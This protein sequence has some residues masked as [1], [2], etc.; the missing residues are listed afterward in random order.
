V[1]EMIYRR[2]GR[3]GLKV[4]L[5]SFGS[6]VTFKDQ[7]DVQRAKD[8]LAAAYDAGVNFFDNAEAYA[9]GESE[10]MMGEAIQELGWPRHSF[11]VSSKYYWGLHHDNPN[12][13]FTLNRKYL[14]EAIDASL[15]RFGLDTLDL[16]FCHRADKDTPIEETVWAMSDAISAGK[17]YYW[18]TSE[19]S[20]DEIRAAWDIAER[21]HLHKPV[22]EQPQYNLFARRRVE[23]EY[24]RL[25]EDIGLGTTIW[26]PLAS[27]LLTG[28]YADG[29]PED[30]RGALEGYEW[31]RDR[32]TDEQKNAA[33]L[34]LKTIADELDCTLAQLA[35]AWCARNPDVST[36]ITGASRPEQVEENM[37]ALDVLPRIT[38][39]VAE[40]MVAIVEGG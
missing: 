3:S 20:A 16:I 27:G 37:K 34:E 33:V 7:I 4:S 11:V 21:H 23:R 39:E 25:Y 28:K 38:D 13:R 1:T 10:R 35:I 40:R 30:S 22:M 29:V 31:L 17:A 14:T 24:R 15:E 5:L 32:L 2:L 26:S 6:W 19:W 8:C 18:G 9:G 36:V 12:H